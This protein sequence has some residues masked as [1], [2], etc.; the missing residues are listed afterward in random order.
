MIYEK[1]REDRKMKVGEKKWK[2]GNFRRQLKFT[3]IELLVVIAI[4]SILSSMLLPALQNARKSA[5]QIACNNK[6]KQ[7]GLSFH[8][9]TDDNNNWLPQQVGKNS[10]MEWDN[11]LQPYLNYSAD[12]GPPVFHCPAGNQYESVPFWQSLGYGY[13]RYVSE[14]THSGGLLNKLKSDVVLLTDLEYPDGTNNEYRVNK[15]NTNPIFVDISN[16]SGMIAYRHIGKTNVLYSD[17]HSMS[18]NMGTRIS[19]S[20]EPIPMETR[21]YPGGDLY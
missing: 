18:R 2:E 1:K 4:I 14:S 5:K 16:N 10:G 20:Y 8:L 12:N 3:L 7:L 19:A 9:Y 6:L 21:W 17:G 13:N 11:R 15:G